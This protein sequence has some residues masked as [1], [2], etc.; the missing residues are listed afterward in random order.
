M[1]Q[2]IEKLIAYYGDKAALAR[3]CNVQWATV[4]RWSKTGKPQGAAKPLLEIL[5]EKMKEN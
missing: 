4:D 2:I 5:Y 1:R 3:V